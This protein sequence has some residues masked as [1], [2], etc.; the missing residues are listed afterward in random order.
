[1]V[2]D[3]SKSVTEL[4]AMTHMTRR[5]RTRCRRRK[6][7]SANGAEFNRAYMAEMVSATRPPW[8]LRA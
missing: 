6:L 5:R 4:A 8:P 3:H 2:T 7:A 1:M